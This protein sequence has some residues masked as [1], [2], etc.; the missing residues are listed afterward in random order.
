MRIS[1]PFTLII[2]DG[3]TTFNWGHS[4]LCARLGKLRGLHDG[5]FGKNTILEKHKID[6]GRKSNFG[7]IAKA[8]KSFDEIKSYKQTPVLSL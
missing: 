5:D 7:E 2:C 1:M 3:A 6:N 4:C 8:G